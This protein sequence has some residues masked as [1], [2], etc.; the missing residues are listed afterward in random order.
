MSKL[1]FLLT[2]VVALFVIGVIQRKLESVLVRRLQKSGHSYLY[3]L[4][5]WIGTPLHELAHATMCVVFRHKIQDIVWVDPVGLGGSVSH[6]W[7]TR[8]YYQNLGNVF[9]ATAPFYFGVIV[10]SALT[11][12][13]FPSL[14]LSSYIA[15]SKSLLLDANSLSDVIA[16]LPTVVG[17]TLDFNLAALGEGGWIY[18]AWLFVSTSIVARMIPSNQDFGNAAKTLIY[19]IPLVAVL[20]IVIGSAGLIEVVLA[21]L[22]SVI[23]F[24]LFFI[25]TYIAYIFLLSLLTLILPRR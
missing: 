24:W 14:P 25:F 22:A 10:V 18:F 7:N 1:V 6:S 20:L 13:V 11:H 5:R 17:V 21:F 9:I 4:T 12:F 8:S 19:G 3:T 23:V 2:L 15:S 16:V